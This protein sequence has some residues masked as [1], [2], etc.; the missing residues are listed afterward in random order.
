[1]SL[2]NNKIKDLVDPQEAIASIN[3]A[4]TLKDKSEFLFALYNV[5]IA[6]GV[7]KLAE[8]SG[9]NREGLYKALQ[10]SGNPSISTL[11]IILEAMGF[12]LQ[13]RPMLQSSSIEQFKVQRINSLAHAYPGL[14]AQWHLQKNQPF[15]AKD[16]LAT[17]RKPVWWV[18]HKN[19]SHEWMETTLSRINRFKKY[20]L[21]SSSLTEK[22]FADQ[23]HQGCPHC[24]RNNE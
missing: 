9:L 11:I 1:M 2:Y 17:S 14:A 4:L 15:S 18:C 22:T 24:A 21:S 5:A 12:E 6:Q 20:V 19:T 16:I 7:S 10:P 8:R 3:I 13:I 23:L